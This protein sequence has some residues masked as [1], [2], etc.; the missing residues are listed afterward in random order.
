MN[1]RQYCSRV[2]DVIKKTEELM[3][4]RG[5]PKGRSLDEGDSLELPRLV[6][7]AGEEATLVPLDDGS[8][9]ME[10]GDECRE[11]KRLDPVVYLFALFLQKESNPPERRELAAR[12]LQI[13]FRFQYNKNTVRGLFFYCKMNKI[14]NGDQY[15]QAMA[16]A[17]KSYSDEVA[18]RLVEVCR[19]III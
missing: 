13:V 10:V 3:Q 4:K 16:M 15:K 8:W 11:D 2:P 14:K 12:F 18:Q 9:V 5:V 19:G 6:F 1:E 7:V 17:G